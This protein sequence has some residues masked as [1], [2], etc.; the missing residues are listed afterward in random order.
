MREHAS[1]VLALELPFEPRTRRT[2]FVA[3]IG[4]NTEGAEIL[5]ADGAGAG[6]AVYDCGRGSVGRSV[7]IFCGSLAAHARR[8]HIDPWRTGFRWRIEGSFAAIVAD[9]TAGFAS[10]SQAVGAAG[11]YR[12]SP[13]TM[14]PDFSAR[15]G[16]DTGLQ[17]ERRIAV[18]WGGE[19]AATFQVQLLIRAKDRAGLL[20]DITAVISGAGSNIHSLESRPDRLNA[21]IDASLEIADR[22]QL[23]TILANI[24]K[25][26]GIHGVE[27]VY[28]V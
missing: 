28:Q 15:A 14:E 16:A 25:V 22:R 8:F 4:G 1:K 3:A 7:V 11:G 24:R 21:R 26:S 5:E 19:G 10:Q 27:R 18:E 20:A 13:I 17:T 23:E 2:R 9:L 6:I 12:C